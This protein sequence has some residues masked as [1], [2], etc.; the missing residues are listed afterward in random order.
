MTSRQE[1]VRRAAQ[2]P[3]ACVI[4]TEARGIH[5]SSHCIALVPATWIFKNNFQ[6]SSNKQRVGYPIGGVRSK[7]FAMSLRY[8]KWRR[9]S[10]N[11]FVA[12]ASTRFRRFR[13]LFF[14]LALFLA[15]TC[16][17]ASV[18]LGGGE[19]EKAVRIS[20]HE[21]GAF[22]PSKPEPNADP[23]LPP[24]TI[25]P[26]VDVRRPVVVTSAA[27]DFVFLLHAGKLRP[28]ICSPHEVLPPRS[29]ASV[30][31]SRSCDSEE[32]RDGS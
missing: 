23:V 13:V 20:A 10:V 5:A 31:R 26:P 18:H 6:I 11:S 8:R 32:A 3:L 28:A 16:T 29:I 2:R 4:G 19:G 24:T 7:N 17:T 27:E 9:P 1:Y 14:F 12:L 21:P 30:R 22:L 25:P 15:L